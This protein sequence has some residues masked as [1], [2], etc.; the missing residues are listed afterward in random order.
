MSDN[1]E[2][3]EAI[4]ARDM[5][6][7]RKA[8]ELRNVMHELQRTIQIHHPTHGG[9]NESLEMRAYFTT[10]SAEVLAPYMEALDILRE[11]IYASDGCLGH[12]GCAHSMEPWQRARKL[13]YAED[14]KRCQP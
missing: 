12:R 11:I 14:D 5:A 10:E 4:I 2:G 3:L 7:G 13:L 6:A 8:N 1:R 9:P